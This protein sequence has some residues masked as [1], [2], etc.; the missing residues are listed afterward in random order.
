MPDQPSPQS[1][2]Q[3][4]NPPVGV[5]S[6]ETGGA[7]FRFV[8]F[9]ALSWAIALVSSAPVCA[10][11]SVPL[12]A[13]VPTLDQM[14]GDWKK[15]TELEQFPSVYNFNCG[16]HVNKDFTSVSWLTSPPF[17][18]G[19]HSG[20]FMLN[21]KVP[22]VDRFLWYPYQA[23]RAGSADGLALETVNRMVFGK[24]GVL[25]R[26][27][28]SNTQPAEVAAKVSIDLIGA[29]SKLTHTNSWDW[30]FAQPG[31]GGPKRRYEETEA[32][33]DAVDKLPSQAPGNAE[34][35]T[36]KPTARSASS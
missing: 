7:S 24:R 1:S 33:R 34:D 19:F 10:A 36:A 18:Q 27:T 28:L 5:S 26:I 4:S 6:P 25:W 32:A 20:V 11:P 9:S 22:V 8:V 31:A 12:P 35:Y 15:R 17:S 2:A 14:A 13:G 29:I 23:V 16:M 21:G 3:T 30:A